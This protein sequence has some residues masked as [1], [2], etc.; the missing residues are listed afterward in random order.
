MRRPK[1]GGYVCEGVDIFRSEERERVRAFSLRDLATLSRVLT[2]HHRFT[3]VC[4]F[5]IRS[6]TQLFCV[7]V[8]ATLYAQGGLGLGKKG[9]TTKLNIK[10]PKGHW[11]VKEKEEREAKEEAERAKNETPRT[12]KKRSKC[13]HNMRSFLC[14]RLFQF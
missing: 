11:S 4:V 3:S 14:I 10:A 8:C 12:R 6:L 9:S 13:V 2:R 1:G 5:C 7:C